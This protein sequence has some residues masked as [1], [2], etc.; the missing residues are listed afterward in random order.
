MFHAKT[1]VGF[2]NHM[3][4]VLQDIIVTYVRDHIKKNSNIGNSN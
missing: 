4:H 1:Y 2:W 3:S